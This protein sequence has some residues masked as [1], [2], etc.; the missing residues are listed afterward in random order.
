MQDIRSVQFFLPGKGRHVGLVR[1]ESVLDLTEKYPDITTTYQLFFHAHTEGD[2]PLRFLRAVDSSGLSRIPYGLLLE[3]EE[4]QDS[5][6]LLIPLDHP[7][8]AHCLVSGA[9]LT[10]LGSASQRAEMH[11][12]KENKTDSEKMFE[13]GLEGGKP[14]TG[15]GVQPGWF[16]KGDG[17]ILRGPNEALEIPSFSED[18]GEE[19]EIG[20]CYVNDLDGTPCRLGFAIGNE[21]SD[22]VTEKTNYLWLAPSKLRSCSLG[23]EL[24]V[25]EQFRSIRGRTRIYRGESV[26]FVS[27]EFRTGEEHMC[28]SLVNLEDHHFKYP[29]FC[30]PGDVHLHYFGA[31]K[32]SFGNCE[33]LAD[34]DRIRIEFEGMR[35]PLVNYV[36]RVPRDDTPVKVRSEGC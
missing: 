30:H 33:P 10:H 29:Q 11:A 1:A 25:T 12:Q 5:P 6:R 14:A 19:P 18:G 28:H 22:H 23:P 21:W 31:V 20:G 32:L 15:R 26:I 16:Y 4:G 35:P 3:G 7:D 24:V 8:P 36:R 13:M 9:G 34:G 27:G 2:S 17:Q